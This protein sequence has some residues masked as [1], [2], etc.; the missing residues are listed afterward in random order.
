MG[1]QSLNSQINDTTFV[2]ETVFFHFCICNDRNKVWKN[3]VFRYIEIHSQHESAGKLY[4]DRV[5]EDY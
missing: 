2:R 1:N 4:L 5:N 3:S